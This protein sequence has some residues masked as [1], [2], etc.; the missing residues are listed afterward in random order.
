MK[1]KHKKRT[2]YNR[3]VI[4]NLM[5]W[6]L[7]GIF[8]LSFLFGCFYLCFQKDSD[9]TN[10]EITQ[11]VIGK[12]ADLYSSTFAKYNTEGKNNLSYTDAR[13]YDIYSIPIELLGLQ[14]NDTLTL[15]NVSTKNF[16]MS[17]DI[18]D[19]SWTKLKSLGWTTQGTSK[20]ISIP[21]GAKFLSFAI[22]KLNSGSD[23]DYKNRVNFDIEDIDINDFIMKKGDSVI[24][25]IGTLRDMINYDDI[26]VS[27]QLINLHN[28]DADQ[29]DSLQDELSKKIYGVL[30]IDLRKTKDNIWLNTHN[31][32]FKNL[33]ISSSTYSQ[34]KEVDDND[35]LKTF[36]ELLDYAKTNKIILQV[37]DKSGG[38][39]D[40]SNINELYGIIN[41]KKANDYVYF[42]NNSYNRLNNV[43]KCYSNAN[44][45]I[46]DV[47]N[48]NCE[49]HQAQALLSLCDNVIINTSFNFNTPLTNSEIEKLN[50]E[51]FKIELGFNHTTNTIK[52]FYQYLKQVEDVSEYIYSIKIDA[53][54]YEYFVAANRYI[55]YLNE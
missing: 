15:E 51:G 29:I 2:T 47:W 46:Y 21:Q 53:G 10:E 3:K 24:D 50:R 28:A 54:T 6:V 48:A 23:T 8:V 49:K 19:E 34:L 42:S 45:M 22:Q 5:I 40:P 25:Y 39:D 26:F 43:V 16:M 35:S 18:S 12:N 38:M 1:D 55:S 33:S 14:V 32:V 30:D 27:K 44:I 13:L 4:S 17:I 7:L 36:E 37:E 31:D 20:S 41:S 52:D 9:L 11:K